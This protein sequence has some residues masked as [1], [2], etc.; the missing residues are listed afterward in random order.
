MI[1]SVQQH[2]SISP[3]FRVTVLGR[4]SEPARENAP[5]QRSSCVK[6]SPILDIKKTYK[7]FFIL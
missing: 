2:I 1:I 7:T 3:G 6:V 4:Y 5:L